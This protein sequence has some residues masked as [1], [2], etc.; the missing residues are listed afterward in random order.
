MYYRITGSAATTDPYTATYQTSEVTPIALGPFPPGNL[1]ITT[2]GQTGG[3]QTDTDLWVYDGLLQAI[4]GW[5]NDDSGVSSGST[6]AR[7]FTTGVYYLAIS[8]F[9]VANNL[10]S[11]A[12]DAFRLGPVLDFPDAALDSIETAA[13][14]S[15]RVTD[16]LGAEHFVSASKSGPYEIAWFQIAIR[17]TTVCYANCDGS[18][19]PPALNVGDFTCFLQAYAIGDPYANC[20]HSTIAPVINAGDFTCFLQKYAIGCS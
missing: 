11:P 16:S 7:P 17:D 10:P 6:L 5:G 8:T 18:T 15:F 12:D 14:V 2:V 1:A 13:N 9:N 3:T 19:S 20:D 4:P